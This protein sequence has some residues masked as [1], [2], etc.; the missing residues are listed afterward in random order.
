MNA[1]G[2]LEKYK[3]LSIQGYELNQELI[4]LESAIRDVKLLG[5]YK[6]KLHNYSFDVYSV[7]KD[8]KAE[9]IS[10]DDLKEIEELTN[11]RLTSMGNYN[12]H[13]TWVHEI[14]E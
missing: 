8:G 3:Q 11:A 12:Y 1:L 4:E 6:L 2:I 7:N 5:K 10:L 9:L 13:F 14:S